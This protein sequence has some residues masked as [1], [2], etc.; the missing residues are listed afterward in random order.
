MTLRAPL[1]AVLFDL[2]GVLLDTE[3]LYTVG[4]QEVVAEFGH[5]YDWSLK[6]DMM[7]RSD[8]EGADLVVSRLK[9]PITAAEYMARR[10]PIMERL[11]ATSPIMTG[12]RELVEELAALGV[13]LALATSSRTRLYEIKAK[14][15]A[16]LGAFRH[17][18]CG[19]DPE[20]KALKPAPDIFL[21]AAARLG[22][23]PELC[24]VVEDSPA[25]V[26][27]AQNAGMQV[28]ALP[29]PEL[30]S[31]IIRGANLVARSHQEIRA[32]L[33]AALGQHQS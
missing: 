16:W 11:L 13:P 27:A 10:E 4:I 19:D 2:D 18:V 28:A 14:P 17:I 5:I 12:A 31:D 24:A 3:P 25:G 7:G 29:D 26:L 22:V 15:H 8:Q 6:R 32:A 23:A 9:L 30:D 20:V 1:S 33:L 21:V